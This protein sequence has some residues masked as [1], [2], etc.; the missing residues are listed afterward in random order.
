MRVLGVGHPRVLDTWRRA[1]AV[2]FDVDCT[3]CKDDSLDAL[4]G[5]LGKS[6]EVEAWTTKAM[7][8]STS[9]LKSLEERMRILDP[10][11]SDVRAYLET[12]PAR[13]RLCEGVEELVGALHERGVAVY[14]ISGGFREMAIPVARAL[15]VESKNVYANR[16]LFT[17]DDETG[18]PTKFAGFD[19]SEPTCRQGGK[20]QVIRELRK[21][22]PYETVVMVGDGITDLE[23]ASEADGAD[24]FI[25]FA[26]VVLRPEVQKGA[27]LVVFDFGTLTRELKRHKV[28]FLGSGA[29]ACAAAKLASE[30][31]SRLDTF[32]TTI[33]MWVYEETYEGR[34]LTEAINETHVNP[35]YLP[36]VSL[37]GNVHAEP[38][39]ETAVKGSDLVVFCVPHEFAL[40]LCNKLEGLLDKDAAVISLTKGMRIRPEGP[41]L[42]SEMLRKKLGRDCSVLMG[43]NIASEIGQGQLSEATIGYAR[44][45]NGK[46]FR[47]LFQTPSFIVTLV[48]DVEGAEMAGTLKNIVA[49]GAGFSDGLGYGSNTKA[50]IIRQGLSEIKELSTRMFPS[51][52]PETFLE[53]C[54]VADLVAS[55]YGGRNRKVA[56]T[57][58][59]ERGERT[60]EELADDL[61]GGQR[62]QGALTAEEV[63]SVLEVKG[64]VADFP[65]FSTVHGIIVG[66]LPVE[67]ITS[68]M[69]SG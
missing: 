55:C 35:K 2:C 26:G 56:E 11:P 53:S 3:V 5:F 33:E 58:A 45:D 42:I 14:L 46:I 64:W 69:G 59:K 52:R 41:Q 20:P 23:A 65:L 60:M 50:A 31:T 51:V 68:F 49:V 30:N 32:E 22:H 61:L 43:A 19:R 36:G 39:L 48:P 10:S 9:L 57:F 1:Q 38:D 63:Y 37:G 4:A 47:D 40:G 54:G 34:P 24:C 29:W 28:C 27:D 21:I 12:A 44:A 16:M 15:G 62:L 8:G 13:E 6:E 66:Q 7:D 25:G 67:S 17:S 18:L